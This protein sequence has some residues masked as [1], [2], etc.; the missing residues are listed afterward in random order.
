MRLNHPITNDETEV[1][2]DQYLISKTDLKGRITFCNPTF[3]QISGFTHE[4]LM[5]KPHNIV[6]HPDMPPAIFKEMWETLEARKPWV[7][8]VKNRRKE[9][10]FYWVLATAMPIIQNGQCVGYASVRVKPRP[11]QV[12]AAEAFYRGVNAGNWG[13]YTVKHGQPVPVGWRKA[14]ARAKA[15]FKPGLAPSLLRT[16][17]VMLGLAAIPTYLASSHLN[18]THSAELWAGFGTIS[19]LLMFSTWRLTRKLER[20]L[21][22]AEEMARQIMGGNLVIDCPE[23]IEPEFRSLF[24]Y[25]GTMRKSLKGIAEDVAM[26]IS[27]NVATVEALLDSSQDLSV[28]TEQ[29]SS[30]LQ[31]TAASLEELTVTV[32][33]NADNAR[34]ANRLSIESMG[35]AQNGGQVVEEVVQTM[36]NIQGS[37]RQIAEI[38]SLIDGISFQTNIL[39]LNAAV[40]AARAGEKG[41]GFAVVASEVRS[42]AQKTSEASKEIR[43]LIHASVEGID[44]GYQKA[45]NARKIM[46]E[47]VASVQ[48]VTEI[49]GEISTAS[50]EQ[51]KGLE[52]IN[53]AV[54]Q[55]DSVTQHNATFVHDL[56]QSAE[57]LERET[58]RL[59]N[60]INVFDTK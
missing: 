39:A 7:G 55:M 54:S 19:A 49:M 6:R 58:A 13:G 38:V 56:Q 29:Q 20:P 25:L 34:E 1:L 26:G 45:E 33:Q 40:E 41:K 27:S 35:V 21:A 31:E 32:K 4:E 60:S 8:V 36:R 9:G 53:Q 37:S 15:V 52:Q 18:A 5:G 50:V 12:R 2:E 30:S 57:E 23:D 47:T 3:T 59:K 11:E 44:L 43:N 28:R 22:D 14:L 46:H 48:R 42:L 10:G 51:A 17:V 16:T 24:F